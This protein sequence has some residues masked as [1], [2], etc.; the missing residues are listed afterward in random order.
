[1]NKKQIIEIRTAGMD[2]GAHYMYHSNTLANV[3]KDSHI[4]TKCTKFITPYEAAIGN[5]DAVLV[6][7]QKSLIS[8]QIAEADRV[9]D[10]AYRSYRNTVKA[11]VSL[12]VANLAEAAKILAQHIKDYRIDP[13]MQLDKE[14]GLL[15]NF[16]ADLTGK[17]AEQVATL[18]LT[19]VVEELAEANERVN[20]LIVERDKENASRQ[21]GLTKQTREKVDEAYREL[22]QVI[23]A[24]VLI[25]GEA[26][27]AA[28]IDNQNAIIQRY[29]QQVLGQTSGSKTPGEEDEPTP[30][31]E[32]PE[33]TAVYQKEGGDPENPNRIERGEQTGVN[34]K[35]FTLKGA[36]GTLEHV[37]GLVNDQDYIEWIKAATIT[38]VTETSCEFT[39]V[40]DLTEGQYKVRIETYDG[41][42]PL[43]VEYPEPIT[44]W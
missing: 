34:Y 3:K 1:M 37:I 4:S 39:M 38:N 26:D 12:P 18:N 24:Y 28:F 27:Y 10:E 2:N 36:D 40:P 25:E 16:T 20:T 42:S 21:V 19:S 41:G 5:E 33:I 8:D 17:F 11:M 9:R 15:R 23:N 13:K 6:I 29:K 32:T 14:T 31:P 43:V 30:E 7:S 22:I 44:L 35:G